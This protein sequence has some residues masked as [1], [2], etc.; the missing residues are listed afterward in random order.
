MEVKLEDLVLGKQNVRAVLGDVT[1][2][3]EEI[4]QCPIGIMNSLTVRMVG[5]KYE[6]IAGRRRYEAAKKLGLETVPVNIV[7]VSDLEAIKISYD[8]NRDRE[9]LQAE[10][11]IKAYTLA[12][13][14]LGDEVQKVAGFFN[15]STDTVYTRM[16]QHACMQALKDSGI[17]IKRRDRTRVKPRGPLS[18]RQADKLAAAF[19]SKR[20]RREFKRAGLSLEDEKKKYVELA[21]KLTALTFAESAKVLKQFRASPLSSIEKII[22]KAF[23]TP[24]GKSYSVYCSPNIVVIIEKISRERQVTEGKFIYGILE[25]WLVTAGYKI[26]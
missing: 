9:N 18:F 12:M 24:G 26:A 15:V 1:L 22:E 19:E 13:E 7:E 2:L 14:H 16:K 6:I 3:A 10:D 5:D 25:N 8:E 20:V 17:I 23:A 11:E 4:R 21:K